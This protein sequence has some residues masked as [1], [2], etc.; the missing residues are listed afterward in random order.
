MQLGRIELQTE[1]QETSQYLSLV[2]I[3]V[4]IMCKCS[5]SILAPIIG[6]MYFNATMIITGRRLYHG[7]MQEQCG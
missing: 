5:A 1:R 4:Y 7:K 2:D 6:D 3:G